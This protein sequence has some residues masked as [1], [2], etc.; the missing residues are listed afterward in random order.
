MNVFP[1]KAT[2]KYRWRT[3]Q[4]K[5]LDNM[6]EHL[7]NGHLHISAPPGSGKTVLGLEIMLRLDKPALI[8]A[9]TLAIKN[10][11]IQRFCEL[12]LDTENIPE[13]ISSDIKNPGIITV[14]TYQGIHSAYGTDEDDEDQIKKSSRISVAE[15]IKKLEKQ[16][17]GTLILDEAHH[18]KNAWWRSLLELKNR[19][20]PTI[21]A[22]TATPPFDVSGAEWQKYIQLNGPIDVEISVPELMI[23]GD[24]CPH[25][26]LVYFTSPSKEEEKKI[27]Y[28]HHQAAMFFEEVQND[29]TL[30]EALELHPV[31]LNPAVHLEWIYENISSYT[32]GLVY[33]HFRGKEIS[34]IHF[35]IIGDQQKYVPGFDFF[36]MEELLDFYLV[37]DEVNFKKYEEHRTD[38]GNRLR[39]AGFLE[40][41]TV[42][43]YNSKN[44]NQILNSSIGKLQGIKEIADFEFSVLKEDLR[45]VILTDF[46]R[47]EY[48]VTETQNTLNLDKIGAVPIFEKLRREN[49][50]HKKIG[51]L[52]GSL[53]IIPVSAK[54]MFEQFCFRK[55][56]SGVSFSPLYYDQ[57]YL[58]ISL[59]DQIKH[60]VVQIITEIF[61]CG[62][63]QILIGTKS[64]LGEGWDAPK[65]NSLVLASFVSSFV[66]SNQMRGRVIRTDKDNV[67]KTGNIWHMVC[68][69][70]H[71]INGGQDFSNIQK[72]FK[73]F[74]GISY[75]DEATIE[76]NFERL[77]IKTIERKEE[78]P[79]INQIFFAWAKNRTALAQRWKT[80]L[81]KGNV[82]VEEI[83]VPSV[84]M[85]GMEKMRMDYLG[86]MSGS[87][88]KIIVSS[89][90]L[91]CQD[92]MMGLLRNIDEI[93]S[94][95]SF[96]LL[97]GLFG[98]AGVAVYGGK[99]YRSTK[100]YLRCK[101]VGRQLSSL[102]EIILYGLI[103]QKVICTSIEKLRIVSSS[104]KN[105]NAFC[106]LD[107][108][109]QYENAQFIQTLH[110]L[111]SQID[112]PRYLLKHKRSLLFLKK[113]MYYPIPEIF[114]KNK[115]NAD[116][117]KKLWDKMI[118]KSELVFTR[119]IEGREIL[120]KL[121]FQAL[122]NRNG[123]IEHLH[124][125]TR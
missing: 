123:R 119:T 115:K 71:D 45:M 54:D 70:S 21:V 9:P 6:N 116:F 96:S 75:K 106:Y 103:H 72:R 8:V 18:L 24:L 109:S 78:L 3:Y 28:H 43:F 48:L 5:I 120:L 114:A 32:S 50:Q 60:D 88:A 11:W 4:K 118:G 79:K 42:S 87:F 38:L 77:N 107:G 66:L 55:S 108:G 16:K 1:E 31:Y 34:D 97:V 39:R 74:V 20:S 111:V 81:D 58:I 62:G 30:L 36:W 13:W 83:E 86:K 90:L 93:K 25:Q 69:D 68:F 94:V 59:S 23:E 112:N 65:I 27:E 57:D 12:F 73:T 15:I 63:I 61:Q 40:Q 44:V 104:D 19:I 2:F 33:L 22:L 67:N 91:F 52:T 82:L 51:I 101:D 124:K 125:W 29:D 64:L 117:F 95:K 47:K 99:L 100:Q 92:L 76:N 122:L 10:Q 41:R 26:D 53:V 105:K 102:A 85:A 56:I 35:N 113:D 46:I 7:K 84:N 89:I 80:A 14:T 110:E 17:V 49:F 37:L 121:R 98:I